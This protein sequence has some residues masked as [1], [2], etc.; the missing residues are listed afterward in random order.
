MVLAAVVLAVLACATMGGGHAARAQEPTKTAVPEP[1]KT[2]V[3]EPTKTPVPPTAVPPTQTPWPTAVPP[4]E[5]PWPTAVPPTEEPPTATPWPTAEPPTAVPPS[6]TSAQTTREPTAT[7]IPGTPAMLATS[8]KEATPPVATSPVAPTPTLTA[9]PAGLGQTTAL[10]TPAAGTHPATPSATARPAAAPVAGTAAPPGLS[11]SSWFGPVLLALGGLVFVAGLGLVVW[12]LRGGRPR[13]ARRPPSVE[14]GAGITVAG[15]EEDVPLA[16][17]ARRVLHN[18]YELQATLGEGGMGVVYRAWDRVLVREVA[19]K[20]LRPNLSAEPD[21]CQQFF[22]EARTAAQLNYPNICAIHD[23][24]EDEA[25][26]LFLVLEYIPG[27]DLEQILADFGERLL[28]DDLVLDLADLTLGALEHAHAR[29]VVHRDLKPGNLRIGEGTM[30]VMDFGLS[31]RTAA[32]PGERGP[33]VGTGPYIPPE[34]AR[35]QPGDERSDLYSFGVILYQLCTGKLPFEADDFEGYMRLHA[36]VPAP[37]P[38]TVRPDL[39]PEVAQLLLRLLQKD[40]ADRPQSAQ[41]VRRQIA[42][43]QGRLSTRET[44]RDETAPE[45]GLMVRQE[46]LGVGYWALLGS[47]FLAAL[48]LRGQLAGLE[49]G[50]GP[51]IWTV[52]GTPMIVALALLVPT[53]GLL[54]VLVGA[55][56]VILSLVG[57]WVPPLAVAGALIGSVVVALLLRGVEWRRWRLERVPEQVAALSGMVIPKATGVLAEARAAG[58]RLWRALTRGRRPAA[59]RPDRLTSPPPPARRRPGEA[60]LPTRARE[61]PGLLQ[62]GSMLVALEAAGL[63]QAVAPVRIDLAGRGGTVTFEVYQRGQELEGVLKVLRGLKLRGEVTGRW[64]RVPLGRGRGGKWHDDLSTMVALGRTAA[65]RVLYGNVRLGAVLEEVP[66]EVIQAIVLQFLA[67][68][69]PGEGEVVVQDGPSLQA[70]FAT[71]QAPHLRRNREA[72][73]EGLGEGGRRR[74]GTALSQARVLLVLA[75]DGEDDVRRIEALMGYARYGILPLAVV[76]DPA[77]RVARC[78]W[79]VQAGPEP[80]VVQAQIPAG[81]AE[82]VVRVFAVPPAVVRAVLA[83]MGQAGA[84]KVAPAEVAESPTAPLSAGEF[85]MGLEAA[86]RTPAARVTVPPAGPA[87]EDA[88][89]LVE[90]LLREIIG[91]GKGESDNRA[92]TVVTGPGAVRAG[93]GTGAAEESRGAAA[94]RPLPAGGSEGGPGGPGAGLQVVPGGAGEPDAGVAHGVQPGLQHDERERSGQLGDRVPAAEPQWDTPVHPGEGAGSPGEGSP[95]RPGEP[96]ERLG[97]EDFAGGA[98]RPGAGVGRAV[99]PETAA[100]AWSDAL[101]RLF[102]GEVTAEAVEDAAGRSPAPRAATGHGAGPAAEGGPAADEELDLPLDF[103]AT[104]VGIVSG[105]ERTSSRKLREALKRHGYM[106]SSA[107][108]AAVLELLRQAGVIGTAEGEREGAPVIIA[109]PA[110][111]GVLVQELIAQR[112]RK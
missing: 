107:Q 90:R 22:E 109:D 17:E 49:Q 53:W 79:R 93:P 57:V 63:G 34:Q 81:T 66:P 1:T 86:S 37:D 40:P 104:V 100:P 77:W 9:A 70:L 85:G 5:T 96:A 36:N 95:S 14:R 28:P 55:L 27:V 41:A 4:T 112:Q 89:D 84:R 52:V 43:W 48:V 111:A 46:W 16:E 102:E 62:V 33:I 26:N 69:A 42:T 106:L 80:G 51:G 76:P 74:R 35:G 87:N 101:Q 44:D 78:G 30:K 64:L 73:R 82:E 60:A 75:V 47:I 31:R 103:L 8:T 88:D 13:A 21:F 25:G 23:V 45:A 68:N 18:R 54:P 15:D 6:N 12:Q 61:D 50:L 108:G 105:Q 67:N 56:H 92:G 99:V 58:G 97:D 72:Y 20:V 3:P 71:W 32:D 2:P 10:A 94:S 110:A 59:A 38:L 91:G 24:G 83:E 11:S 29:G 98:G 7:P 19:V 39:R 65:G